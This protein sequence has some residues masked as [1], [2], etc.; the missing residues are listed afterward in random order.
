MN[1]H[2]PGGMQRLLK[3]AIPP[4]D[5]ELR[6]DLWAAMRQKLDARRPP[7]AWYDWALAAALGG[8]V[9]VSPE[10]ILLVLYH[11]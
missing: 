3:E 8:V 7:I 9:A 1:E 6:R 4:V 5:T 10:L 2:D 11:L